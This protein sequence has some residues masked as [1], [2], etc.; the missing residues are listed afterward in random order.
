L[1]AESD[2]LIS[3]HLENAIAAE[4]R[5][6]AQFRGFSQHG[7][8]DEVQTAFATQADQIRGGL[9]TLAI[10]LRELGGGASEGHSELS[11]A[12]DAAPELATSGV[13]E[14][15][16]LQDLIAACTIGATQCA[17]YAV[18]ATVAQ[19]A[20]DLKTETL[21]RQME[22]ERRTTTDRVWHFLPSRSKIAFNMLTLDEVDPAVE[23]RAIE[24]RLVE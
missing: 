7:D 9:K 6:E 3:Q 22:E 14:E 18:L 16:T 20:G 21:A 1:S 13:S 19:A 8:D 2:A 23:T 15:Q 10:R 17:M 4:G 12:T 24:N 11:H 5:F